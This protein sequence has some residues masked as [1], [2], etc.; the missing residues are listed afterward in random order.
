MSGAASETR[1]CRQ[2]RSAMPPMAHPASP[3]PRSVHACVASRGA[4]RKRR[5]LDAVQV[6]AQLADATAMA[7]DGVEDAVLALVQRRLR[8]LEVLQQHAGRLA[9]PMPG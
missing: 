8:S 5:A 3:M 7:F 4:R 9:G 2:A 6:G 1:S